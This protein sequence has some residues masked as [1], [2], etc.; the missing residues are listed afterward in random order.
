MGAG[1][2]TRPVSRTDV[3]RLGKRGSYRLGGPGPLGGVRPVLPRPFQPLFV[4]PQHQGSTSGWMLAAGAA[5]IV[6]AG[7]AAAGIWYVPFI[8]GVVAGVTTR[9]GGWRLR[10]TVPAV[11]IMSTGG[12][13][14]A[15][16]LDALRGLPVGATARTIAMVAGLPAGAAATVTITLAVSAAQG[17]AGLWLGRALAPRPGRD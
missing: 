5:T 3:D 12:W 8:I 14:L 17:L 1:A 7:A 6:I 10:V 4:R 9:W 15:L 13:G 16:L 11:T 2:M